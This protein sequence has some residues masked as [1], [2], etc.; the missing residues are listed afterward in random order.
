MRIRKVK[1][2]GEIKLFNKLLYVTQSLHGQPVGIEQTDEDSSRLWYC[3]YL[4]GRIDHRNWHIIPAMS[5]QIICPGTWA[6]EE[7]KP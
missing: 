4:L 6:A 5:T 3:S 2:S 7:H 1:G